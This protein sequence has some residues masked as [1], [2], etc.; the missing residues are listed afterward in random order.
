[1]SVQTGSAN[2]LDHVRQNLVGL[3]MARALEV[4]WGSVDPSEAVAGVSDGSVEGRKRL[5]YLGVVLRL[6]NR[7]KEARAALEKAA[8]LRSACFEKALAERELKKLR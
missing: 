3:K 7:L 8:S 6:G 2:S 5:Y 1:M 4:L